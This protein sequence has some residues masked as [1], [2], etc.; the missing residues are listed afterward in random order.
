M[1]AQSYQ[2][3]LHMVKLGSMIMRKALSDII[4]MKFRNLPKYYNRIIGSIST[5]FKTFQR[6]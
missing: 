3:L 4:V 5:I 1:I 2:P 6:G